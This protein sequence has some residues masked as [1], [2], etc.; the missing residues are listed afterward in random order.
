MARRKKNPLGD[1]EDALSSLGYGSQEGGDSVTNID[2]QDVVNQVLDDPN[3]AIDNLDN[4]D[5]DESTEDKD[6]KN[7]TG[8]PNAHDDDTDI[9]DNILNNT[10]TTTVDNSEEDETED[11]VVIDNPDNNQAVDPG[12]AEQIGAFFDAFAEAN[13]WSVT[14][15]E[16]P[17]SVEDLVDYIKDVVDEN[18]TPQYADERI[19]KLDQYVK[20]GGRFEDFYQT[21]QRSMSFDNIDMEDES[22]QK[23]VVRDYYKLQGM[24]DEQISRKIERYEDADMLE[25]E[26]ADAVTYLKAYEQQ[27][28]EYLA[29]QQEAQRQAQ[30]QQAAQFMNDLTTSINGLTNIRGIAIPKEDR[31]ALYDYITRTDADGLTQYQKDFNGNLVNNLLESAYF[32]MKGDALLGEAQ[33]NGQT[34]AASKLR[35]MLKHQTKNHS[36][37]NV[38]HEKQPQAWDIASKYL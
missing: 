2:N 13:G 12:E 8:D 38:G 35:Q 28:Q 3:D 15:D 21:Q 9:P 10:S 26:A 18:S 32:T 31:R 7:V 22:N 16:K 36:S 23:A 20:N 11:E 19:A 17:K 33:R 30:E 37:Y 25:D 24:S 34:S 29:Q 5:G 27:Q 4:P 1:F 6:K 14:D